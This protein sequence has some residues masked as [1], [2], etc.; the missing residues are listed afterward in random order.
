MAVLAKFLVCF[1]AEDSLKLYLHRE[2]AESYAINLNVNNFYIYSKHANYGRAML[3][4]FL[5]CLRVRLTN[6]SKNQ[7]KQIRKR[8]SKLK[9]T[10]AILAQGRL[11]SSLGTAR[12]WKLH[13]AP[14]A[15]SS[16][17]PGA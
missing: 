13:L 6:K 8:L 7:F 1:K 3:A 9:G 12:L 10:V 14:R 11:G 2:H 16:A 4:K 17:T 5:V 15:R